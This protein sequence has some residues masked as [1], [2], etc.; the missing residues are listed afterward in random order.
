MGTWYN[1]GEIIGC[2][3]WYGVSEKYSPAAFAARDRYNKKTYDDIKIRVPKGMRAE[4][5]KDADE[6]G[7]SLNAYLLDALAKKKK[8]AFNKKVDEEER[9]LN[10]ITGKANKEKAER[11]FYLLNGLNESGKN[12]IFAGYQQ[13]ILFR[14]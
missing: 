3:G 11:A 5:K 8:N 4:L 7:K 1:I 6:A 2:Q 13:R 12:S 14:S 9:L 10:G